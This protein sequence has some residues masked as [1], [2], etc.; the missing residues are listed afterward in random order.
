[1]NVFDNKKLPLLL[2]SLILVLLL[3]ACGRNAAEETAPPGSDVM[4]EH[5]AETEA[6]M[7]GEDTGVTEDPS[8]GEAAVSFANQV[9][10]ILQNY[11]AQCHSADRTDAGLDVLNYVAL[12]AGGEDGPVV[13]PGDADASLFVTLVAEQ[14]MPKSGPKLTPDQVQILAD[15]VNQGALDN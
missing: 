10:P 13:I 7:A 11:C 9:R 6:P 4:D 12:M 5:P 15:W 14:R 2:L 8:A 3:A 1:M